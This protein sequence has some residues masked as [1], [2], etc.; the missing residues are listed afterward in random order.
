MA[1]AGQA[2]TLVAG[3]SAPQTEIENYLDLREKA[4]SALIELEA[5]LLKI[6]AD[7]AQQVASQAASKPKLDTDALLSQYKAAKAKHDQLLE[8]KA[9]V[10][11]LL[12]AVSKRLDELKAS[13]PADFIIVLK[14]R[15]AE[16]EEVTSK[17]HDEAERAKAALEELNDELD[18]IV[19]A[20]PA[21]AGSAAAAPAPAA[22]PRAV[23]AATPPAR[24]RR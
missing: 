8:K 23:S 18:E 15:I 11:F 6:P 21:A 17:E 12:D 1:T 4:K 2:L 3:K 14:Q 20:H 24:R 19:K 22:G 10:Q 5:E 7:L 13:S 16:Q 9:A